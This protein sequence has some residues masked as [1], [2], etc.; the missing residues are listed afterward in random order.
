MSFSFPGNPLIMASVTV[1]LEGFGVF[2]G[3]YLITKATHTLGA[4]YSTSIDV[5][6]CLNGY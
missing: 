5:R 2:D 4:N 3:N 1:K 6:R